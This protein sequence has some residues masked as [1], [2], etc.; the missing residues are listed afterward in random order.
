MVTYT[1]NPTTQEAEKGRPYYE[2][3]LIQS[4]RAARATENLVLKNKNK[5]K[6]RKRFKSY[7]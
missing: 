3:S 6:N 5:N 2:G 7:H 4:S 1:F